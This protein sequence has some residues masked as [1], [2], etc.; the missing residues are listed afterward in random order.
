MGELSLHDGPPQELLFSPFFLFVVLRGASLPI[1]LYEFDVHDIAWKDM[2]GIYKAFGALLFL[3]CFL[4][5]EGYAHW[6]T[7]AALPHRFIVCTA[8][9]SS[10]RPDWHLSDIAPVYQN[11]EFSCTAS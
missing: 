11:T 8:F 4:L 1:P 6:T 5:I 3:H 7:I 10:S 9:P 2:T